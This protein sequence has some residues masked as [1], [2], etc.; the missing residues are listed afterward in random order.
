MLSLEWNLKT[1]MIVRRKDALVVYLFNKTIKGT[2]LISHSESFVIFQ[3]GKNSTNL[4][5]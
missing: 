5:G 2:L 4:F 1:T 3:F